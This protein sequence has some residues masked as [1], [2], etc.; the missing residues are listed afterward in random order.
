MGPK[1]PSATASP[2]QPFQ[3]KRKPIAVISAIAL[4]VPFGVGSLHH[5][6]DGGFADPLMR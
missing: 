3:D 4:V 6:T 1:P 5:L 2:R